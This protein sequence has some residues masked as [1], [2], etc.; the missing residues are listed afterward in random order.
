MKKFIILIAI[1]IATQIANAQG[2]GGGNGSQAN[3]YLIETKE[4]LEALAD[5]VNN[6]DPYL[7]YNWSVGKYFKV[8]NDITDSVRTVIGNNVNNINRFMGHFDGQ[9]YKITLA[10]D[11]S[12][13]NYVGLFGTVANSS[14]LGVISNATIENVIVDG[15][16]IGYDYV[17]GIMGRHGH[18]HQ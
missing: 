4:H 5:S 10:I 12:T 3:P 15:Y 18:T 8:M 1:A 14:F 7:Y 2:F 16:V 11:K 9:G 17:A 13:E 6:S